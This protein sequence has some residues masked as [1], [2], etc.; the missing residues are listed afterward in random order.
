MPVL[1]KFFS[2]LGN[3]IDE[4]YRKKIY[5]FIFCSVVASF[6]WLLVKLS[7]KYTLAVECNLS[8]IAPEGKVFVT[9]PLESVSVN[10][11]SEGFNL[12]F[13]HLKKQ[14]PVKI[15]LNHLTF[16]RSKN[17]YYSRVKT[18]D[19]L[20]K[21]CKSFSFYNNIVSANPE[22]L[23]FRYEKIYVKKVPVKLNV[24][25]RT[26]N[27]YRIY[28]NMSYKPDSVNIYG[29][30]DVIEKIP[31]IETQKK[32]LVNVKN[33]VNVKV[34]LTRNDSVNS[35]TDSIYVVVPV[36]KYTEA[37]VEVPVKIINNPNN[38]TVRTFPDKVQIIYLVALKDYKKVDNSMFFVEADYAEIV[39]D[40]D[41]KIKVNISEKPDLVDITR[42]IPESVEYIIIK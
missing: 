22:Y 3:R 20:K 34:S 23:Y 5:I 16:K 6:L 24:N 18:S 38:V 1:K 11:R 40:P 33:N 7:D 39:D 17:I 26:A 30:K 14:Y 13:Y 42:V 29:R 27:Q 12:F 28:G 35:F 37:S 41:S 31:Y 19:F 21:Y 4:D 32:Y 36:E 25:I 15:D 8:Y 2:R 10:I 9:K